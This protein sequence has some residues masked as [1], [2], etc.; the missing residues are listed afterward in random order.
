MTFWRGTAQKGDGKVP[1]KTPG[2]YN[3]ESKIM[4]KVLVIVTGGLI[5]LTSAVFGQTLPHTTSILKGDGVGGAAAAT[6]ADIAALGQ[7]SNDVNNVNQKSCAVNGV[8]NPA[9]GLNTYIADPTGVTDSTAAIQAALDA[10]AVNTNGNN[11]VE[12]P[13]GNFLIGT[14]INITGSTTSGSPTIT[15]VSSIAGLVVG[16]PIYGAGIPAGALIAAPA[17]LGTTITLSV[18][19]TATAT[20]VG[21]TVPAAP[22]FLRSHVKLRGQGQGATKIIESMAGIQRVVTSWTCTPTSGANCTTGTGPFYINMTFATPPF[23]FLIAYDWYGGPWT[24]P[25]GASGCSLAQLFG[26]S[27]TNLFNLSGTAGLSNLVLAQYS[28]FSGCTSQAQILTATTMQ[29]KINSGTITA[30]SGTGGTFQIPLYPIMSY[31]ARHYSES[32]NFEIADITFDGQCNACSTANAPWQQDGIYLFHK[33][34]PAGGY[35]TN[36]S[37]HNVTFQNFAV[38]AIDMLAL[39]GFTFKDM[40]CTNLGQSCIGGMAAGNILVDNVVATNIGF[41]FQ[42]NTGYYFSA[43]FNDGV[44]CGGYSNVTILNSTFKPSAD[45]NNTPFG[46][47]FYQNGTSPSAT[48]KLMHGVTIKNFTQVEQCQ[49]NGGMFSGFVDDLLIDGITSDVTA[50]GTT[51]PPNGTGFVEIGG[52]NNRVTNGHNVH[53]VWAGIDSSYVHATNLQFDHLTW[54]APYGPGGLVSVAG[55]QGGLISPCEIDNIDIHDNSVLIDMANSAPTG[56]IFGINSGEGSTTCALRNVKIHDN[57]LTSFDGANPRSVVQMAGQ[58]ML[59][60]PTGNTT[61]GGTAVTSVSSITGLVVG[62][63]IT[64]PGIPANTTI[65][66]FSPSSITLSANATATATGVTFNITILPNANWEIYNNQVTGFAYLLQPIC[67]W[68]SGGYSGGHFGTTV[69]TT[70]T[71]LRVLNNTADNTLS[72]LINNTTGIP[73]AGGTCYGTWSGVSIWGGNSWAGIDY[74]IAHNGVT[75][76]ITG[77]ASACVT[78]T[79]PSSEFQVGALV[80]ATRSNGALPHIGT[81]IQTS[82]IAAGTATVQVCSGTTAEPAGTFNVSVTNPQ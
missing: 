44:C 40:T 71:N 12:L 3:Q 22:L 4:R 37:I 33:S 67:T 29:V 76:T 78:G 51:S 69:G 74:N 32:T 25:L 60:N 30:N 70:V 75:G 6:S 16:Q 61:S 5:F 7:L 11:T 43:L 26:T 18:N 68:Q 77:T 19:A 66:A 14:A 55:G 53:P 81:T 79:T 52:S 21:L 13:A 64:G 57:Q 63:P 46:I 8:L 2:E 41:P 20:G 27:P 73:P 39:N 48:H 38:D 34:Q 10:A 58:G 42:G 31:D 54:D 82:V 80:S 62:Q 36:G 23:A 49:S 1:P 17:P 24:N 72:T 9:C 59:V 15:A 65:A 45:A 35:V 28:F 47:G 56:P 50:C